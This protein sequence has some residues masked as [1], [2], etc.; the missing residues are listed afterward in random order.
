MED[1]PYLD[2]SRIQGFGKLKAQ[3]PAM[4]YFP[5]FHAIVT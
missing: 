1:I 3:K 2:Q 4:V 5:S